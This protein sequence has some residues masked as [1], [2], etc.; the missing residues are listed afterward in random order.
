MTGIKLA[1]TLANAGI[2]VIILESSDRIG[3]R[4]KSFEFEGQMI[5]DGANW[6]TGLQH[7]ET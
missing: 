3:G 4:V 2:D 7:K 5:E 1:H 6:I